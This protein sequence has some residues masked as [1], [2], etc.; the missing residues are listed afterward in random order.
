V[1]GVACSIVTSCRSTRSSNA[2]GSVRTSS[3]TTTTR[4][5]SVSGSTSSSAEMSNANVVNQ[6]R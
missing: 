4:P 5:P 3:G 6:S 2:A 1:V